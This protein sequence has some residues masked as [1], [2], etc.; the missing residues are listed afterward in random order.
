[1]IRKN[2][3]FS[4]QLLRTFRNCMKISGNFKNFFLIVFVFFCKKCKTISR[5]FCILSAVSKPVAILRK[6]QV[7]SSSHL[8][9]QFAFLTK[10]ILIVGNYKTTAKK[11]RKTA[12]YKCFEKISYF[13][14]ISQPVKIFRKWFFQAIFK[15]NFNFYFLRKKY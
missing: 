2:F 1:M 8:K 3:S 14:I 10:K 11:C 4:Y 13:L 6:F 9:F 7:L 15:V 5:K 12:E